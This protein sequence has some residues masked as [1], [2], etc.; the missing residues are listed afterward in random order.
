MLSNGGAR[1]ATSLCTSDAG[2]RP[3]PLQMLL[4][5]PFRCNVCAHTQLLTNTKL[6][7]QLTGMYLVAQQ[8]LHS[9]R[10]RITAAAAATLLQDEHDLCWLAANVLSNLVAISHGS[11]AYLLHRPHLCS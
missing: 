10:V 2:E 4:Q 9:N 8:Q 5:S 1:Y 3:Q 11:G 7:L 6:Q